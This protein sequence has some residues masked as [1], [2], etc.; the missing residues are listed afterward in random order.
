MTRR[1]D[2]TEL[3]P[4]QKWLLGFVGINIIPQRIGNLR[5]RSQWLRESAPENRG[6]A[7]QQKQ[8]EALTSGLQKVSAQIEATKPAPQVVNNP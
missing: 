3:L 2:N 5:A 7:Q 8:I 6:H 4:R 1:Y